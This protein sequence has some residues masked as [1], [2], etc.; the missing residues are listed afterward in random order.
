MEDT[1]SYQNSMEDLTEL[2][3][4]VV[5]WL[6]NKDQWTETDWMIYWNEMYQ[7]DDQLKNLKDYME[8]DERERAGELSF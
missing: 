8:S 5:E 4:D 6:A 7:W 2:P 1:N 3:E